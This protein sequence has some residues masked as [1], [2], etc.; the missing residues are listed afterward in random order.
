MEPIFELA[1]EL[2]GPGSR[3]LLRTLHA[4]LRGAIVDGRLQPG[5]RLPPTRDFAATFGVSRNT[6]VAAYDLLLSEGYVEARQ[7]DG[8]YVADMP[9]RAPAEPAMPK[10]PAQTAKRVKQADAR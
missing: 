7:G 5:V 1:I 4:Q 9:A 6:A 10:V 8:T 3:E 2:P